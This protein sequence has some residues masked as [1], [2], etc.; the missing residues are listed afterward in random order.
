M[1]TAYAGA[2]D[3]NETCGHASGPAV[4]RATDS[5]RTKLAKSLRKQ[6]LAFDDERYAPITWS[7]LS[8]TKNLA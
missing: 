8:M 4:L 3:W 2:A 6:K 1:A 5:E 7:F